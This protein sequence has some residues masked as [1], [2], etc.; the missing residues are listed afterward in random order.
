MIEEFDQANN[1]GNDTCSPIGTKVRMQRANGFRILEMYEDAEE[2]LSKI[3]PEDRLGRNVLTMNLAVRQDAEDW[4]S[5]LKTARI[6]RHQY[7]D[8]SEWWIAEA[9]AL[10]RSES[11]EAAHEVLLD[12]EKR[13][14]RD[15]C[16]KYNLACY[17]CQKGDVEKA[18]RYLLK[19][20]ELDAKYKKLALADDDLT[21]MRVV[22]L[23]L[24]FSAESLSNED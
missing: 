22:L 9:Y 3:S 10:R 6:L 18:L 14:I 19:A 13:H 17:S 20:V 16:I 8:T 5:M 21:E 2:E 15:A 4:S 11:L 24:G 1:H 23:K 7:P 12:A